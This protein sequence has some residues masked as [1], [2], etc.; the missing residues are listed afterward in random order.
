MTSDCSHSDAPVSTER[1]FA[2]PYGDS[3]EQARIRR[4]WSGELPFRLQCLGR[5]GRVVLNRTDVP[6]AGLRQ[7]ATV[8]V[9]FIELAEVDRFTA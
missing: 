3:L 4:A 9:G 5:I 7:W 1:M 8:E 6:V 2:V